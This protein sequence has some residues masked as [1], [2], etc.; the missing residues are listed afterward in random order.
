M[1]HEGEEEAEFF[2][3]C[4]ERP[5]EARVKSAGLSPHALKKLQKYPD[6]P[7]PHPLVGS[8]YL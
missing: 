6:I 8:I 1:M 2:N 4:K 3:H 7:P 5:R